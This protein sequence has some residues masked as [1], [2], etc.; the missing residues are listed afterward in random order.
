MIPGDWV[1]IDALLGIWSLDGACVIDMRGEH[2][3]ALVLA[4]FPAP[5]WEGY[6]LLTNN[7]DELH[8]SSDVI[9]IQGT[10]GTG[11]GLPEWFNDEEV[12]R[13]ETR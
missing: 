6:E 9:I 12:H 5:D 8:W 7:M 1:N 13:V 2:G 4:R 3:L 11:V 10:F